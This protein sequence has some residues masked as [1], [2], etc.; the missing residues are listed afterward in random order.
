MSKRY[1][2]YSEKN[3]NGI[4][5]TAQTLRGTERYYDKPYTVYIRHAKSDAA[6]HPF[7]AAAHPVNVIPFYRLSDFSCLQMQIFH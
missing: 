3:L 7:A 4:D 5:Q 1:V 2:I 6:V